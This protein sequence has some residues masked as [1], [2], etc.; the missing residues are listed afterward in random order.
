MA[1]LRRTTVAEAPHV[2]GQAGHV[3]SPVLHPHV[4]VV[5]PGMGVLLALLIGE[6]RAGMPT[7]VVDRL[8]PL[9]QFDRPIDALG[10]ATRLP[11]AESDSGE[12]YTIRQ[13]CVRK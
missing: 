6:D 13:D 12:N 2:L 3:E 11:H 4:D 9:K 7:G 5:R 8:V 1:T 10:H